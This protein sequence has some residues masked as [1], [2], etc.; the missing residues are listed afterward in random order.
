MRTVFESAIE[1]FGDLWLY[2]D[3]EPT[4]KPR[5]R[6]FRPDVIAVHP[7]PVCGAARGRPCTRRNLSGVVLRRL[8]HL[9]RNKP[10]RNNYNS[11]SNL[12]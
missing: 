2:S 9:G 8:P 5:P 11:R 3:R 7:C 1:N 4:A 6:D 10:R 12:E